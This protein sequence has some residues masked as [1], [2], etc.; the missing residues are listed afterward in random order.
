M[1]DIKLFK[2]DILRGL[3]GLSGT[4][5]V[6]KFTMAVHDHYIISAKGNVFNAEPRMRF[7]RWKT[8]QNG[9][10]L[11]PHKGLKRNTN[12]CRACHF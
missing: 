8:K 12:A 4:L 10:D 2:Y 3:R 6:K 9:I 1:V 7:R 11:D 5:P